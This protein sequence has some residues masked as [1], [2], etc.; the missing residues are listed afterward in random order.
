[1]DCLTLVCLLERSRVNEF[2]LDHTSTMPPKP[3]DDDKYQP[4]KAA[5]SGPL[6]PS[7]AVNTPTQRLIVTAAFFLL[8]GY[9]LATAK[10]WVSF[11][12]Y[13]ALDVAFVAY[14][15]VLGIPRFNFKRSVTQFQ[16]LL[17]LLVNYSIFIDARWVL[18]ALWL[19]TRPLMLI[20]NPSSSQQTSLS[21]GH[22]QGKYII[23]ILPEASARLDTIAPLCIEHDQKH[24]VYLRLNVDNMWPST[25]SM[26]RAT[27]GDT[28]NYESLSFSKRQ[29]SGLPTEQN[30]LYVPVSKPGAYYLNSITDDQT[31][32]RVRI[33]RT[34]VVVPPCPVARIDSLSEQY[35][36]KDQNLDAE[37]VAEGVMPMKLMIDGDWVTVGEP[38]PED[39]VEE[40]RYKLAK[41]GTADVVAISL[42]SAVDALGTKSK[43]LLDSQV[44]AR[45]MA[46]PTASFVRE[47][48]L[49]KVSE[50]VDAYVN[51]VGNRENQP[52]KVSLVLP[53]GDES[54]ITLPSPGQHKIT[55]SDVG[56]YR[57]RSLSGTKCDG[58][59]Q[60]DLKV[61]EPPQVSVDGRFEV[62]QDKCAGPTGVNALLT[63]GGTA[64]FRVEYRTIKGNRVVNQNVATFNS[65]H[66]ALQ[67][68]PK[69]VG[70]Y[71]YEVISVQDKYRLVSAQLSTSQKITELPGA[72]FGRLSST[73]LCGESRVSAEVLIRGRGPFTLKYRIDD[74]NHHEITTRDATDA[75][76]VTLD[77]DLPAGSHFI[78]L[79]S[80]TDRNGCV[81][82]LGGIRSANIDVI[83][84]LARIGIAQPG[85]Y[86][87]AEPVDFKIPLIARDLQY[88]ATLVFEHELEGRV[89]RFQMTLSSENDGITATKPGIYRLLA[90]DDGQCGG[91][92]EPDQNVTIGLYE[93]PRIE[94]NAITSD[95]YCLGGETETLKAKFYGEAPFTVIHEVLDP[96]RES[97][98][99]T[100]KINGDSAEFPLSSVVPGEYK[101]FFWILDQRYP[102]FNRHNFVE[103]RHTVWPPSEASFTKK[104]QYLRICEN[105]KSPVQLPIVMKGAGPMLLDV[106]INNL[107]IQQHLVEDLSHFNLEVG[108]HLPV[109]TNKISI[110]KIHD[111]HG[112]ISPISPLYGDATVEVLPG[113]KEPQLER[114]DYCVGDKVS[115]PLQGVGSQFS[116]QYQ[117]GNK[118]RTENVHGNKF[119]RYVNTPGN[120]T[121]LSIK[122]EK[123]CQVDTYATAQIHQ[124]PSSTITLSPHFSIYEGDQVSLGFAF[125]GTA[126]FSF[127]YTRSVN[128]KVKEKK[129]VR[130]V[131][132]NV[133]TIIVDQ[134]GEYEIIELQDR[135]CKSHR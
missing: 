93:R 70:E 15:P 20:L 36:C 129:T 40:V 104:K 6:I 94:L 63:F 35:I 61:F 25:I 55:L 42:G 121:M 51:V 13:T 123:G 71:R 45:V 23:D 7:K 108:T 57:L 80:L 27:L 122:D 24:P 114:S 106:Q 59:A 34:R 72:Q 125:E 100:H 47:T 82:D 84:N 19:F 37:I 102:D 130:N 131:M 77:L 68:K 81:T 18:F 111:G 127:V 12:G 33:E 120:L 113:P 85:D 112:C 75:D 10:T 4:K 133:Y 128:G 49:A 48:T 29:L 79:D 11:V 52:F 118:I 3:W 2:C 56:N 53:S 38:S 60:G 103:Q 117:L 1:M 14:L 43:N 126:P 135:Y 83:P 90:L 30:K 41:P 86:K 67:F 74:K 16:I 134:G 32:L 98:V 105:N 58:T 31:G 64:P 62:V 91:I 89:S 124:L 110:V 73:K 69:D 96:M 95:G 101:H 115:V 119:Q 76:K 109:G 132:D 9:K 107:P 8:Q 78:R 116:V 87:S 99:K 97:H 26:S 54:L 66:G 88:P 44:S 65:A 5:G 21:A 46:P 50:T 28:S 39:A 17:L 92:V 22:I